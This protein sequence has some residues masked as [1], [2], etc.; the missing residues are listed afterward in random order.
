MLGDNSKFI[1]KKKSKVGQRSNMIKK[2][3]KKH[4]NIHKPVT[5]STVISL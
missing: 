2:I 5:Y 4:S 3:N 1:A